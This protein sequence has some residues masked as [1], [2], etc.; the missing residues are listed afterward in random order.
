M[1]SNQSGWFSMASGSW[2]LPLPGSGS[3]PVPI[4]FE[5]GLAAPL[6]FTFEGIALL[7]EGRVGGDE[8]DGFGVE[9]SEDV[10][11]VAQVEGVE[12]KIRRLRRTIVRGG[13]RRIHRAIVYSMPLGMPN[14]VGSSV[15]IL[16]N[17][18]SIII[19]ENPVRA[20]AIIPRA[21][22]EALHRGSSGGHG[23]SVRR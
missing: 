10:D 1:D 12:L 9:A 2:R 21:C 18:M 5:L 22:P 19:A 3:T 6:Q 7:V 16:E 20:T 17:P 8:I 4:V 13:A 23:A 14:G 15:F 11:I